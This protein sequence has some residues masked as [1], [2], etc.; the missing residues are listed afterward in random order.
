MS[1]RET[2][3]FTTFLQERFKEFTALFGEQP[4]IV[5]LQRKI[6]PEL[7][8]TQATGNRQGVT[9]GTKVPIFEVVQAGV[10]RL[11]NRSVPL[12]SLNPKSGKKVPIQRASPQDA[13]TV[14]QQKNQGR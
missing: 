13:N 9:R 5:N 1:A 2:V 10:V 11:K 14:T 4:P 6:D 8:R 7:Q 3:D 12:N